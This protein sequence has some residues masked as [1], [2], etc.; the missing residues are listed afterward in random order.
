MN[1]GRRLQ[2]QGAVF[3]C[4]R[5]STH[6][7]FQE[8]LLN[9]EF[10]RWGIQRSISDSLDPLYDREVEMYEAADAVTVPSSFAARSYV[11]SG[12]AKEKVHVIPYGVRLENFKKIAD[13]PRDRFEVLFVGQVVL[14]KGVP[15]LLLAFAGLRHPGKRLRFVGSV[16]PHIPQVTSSITARASGVS[17]QPTASGGGAHYEFKPPLGIAQH[18][19]WI[20]IGSRAGDGV[21]MPCAG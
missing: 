15:Y 16:E 8:S 4:D 3:V 17:R 21:R 18:R 19:G 10:R 9:E 12:I 2:K 20:R 11:E 7:R 6:Q 1:T 14:R 5:G 13:P